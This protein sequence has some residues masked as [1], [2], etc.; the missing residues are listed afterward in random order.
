MFLFTMSLDLLTQ[1]LSFELCVSQGY[2]LNF[3]S[4]LRILLSL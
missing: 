3:V 1:D 4:K 2:M